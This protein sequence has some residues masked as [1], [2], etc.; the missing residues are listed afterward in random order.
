[1][2]YK[3]IRS[4]V[5]ICSVSILVILGLVLYANQAGI[6]SGTSAE[7]SV[8]G[9]DEAAADGQNADSGA[10]AA[11]NHVTAADGDVRAFLYDDT[12][13]D[14]DPEGE[15]TQYTQDAVRLSLIATS[16]Q[17]DLRLRIVD[18]NGELVT[19][20]PFYVTV[21]EVGQFKDLDQDGIIYVGDLSPG[22]YNVSIDPIEGYHVAASVTKVHVKE[23]VEYKTIDDISFFILSESD[24]DTGKDA[25]TSHNLN[26]DVDDTERTDSYTD[27]DTAVMG[28]DVS[29]WNGEIDWEEV[30]ASGIEFAIIR[31]GY[32][33]YTTG[34]LVEDKYFWRN[35]TAA[36]AAG[37]KVGLYFFTQALN[38]VEAV[39]EASMVITLCRDYQVDLPI[40]IDTESTGGNGRADGLDKEMRTTV[41]RA[42]C[43]TI[44]SA[45]Y[46]AGVY[47]S[48]NWFNQMLQAGQ[49]TKYVTWL[50]E[51]KES[52]TYEGDY[53]FWQYTSNGWINGITGRVDLNIGNLSLANIQKSE[54]AGSVDK[55][56]STAGA[57]SA[58]GTENTQN[59][60][61]TDNTVQGE[62]KD[63][64]D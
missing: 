31:C 17:K 26:E 10:Q 29:S 49:L 23:K 8:Q 25:V 22:D 46:H 38:E 32:R 59:T 61:N 44:E 57:D 55:G 52:P 39:E 3:L 15:Q 41:C 7:V 40:F 51:Y 48:K 42:F 24:I 19:G 34:A 54:I 45:G 28:I 30:R 1:M 33:G 27:L 4:T 16:V 20:E 13:W 14:A 5:L 18:G 50:A 58:A 56:D 2:D 35:I 47:A 9:Q 62:N 12:F 36:N 37:V 11:Q 64:E 53:Q 21:E 6:K 43:E 63:G 60:E